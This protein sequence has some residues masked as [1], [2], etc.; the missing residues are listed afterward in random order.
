MPEQTMF[1]VKQELVNELL[2]IS[3]YGES[4]S[5]EQ[6]DLRT[7]KAIFLMEKINASDFLVIGA[8]LMASITYDQNGKR[9]EFREADHS[10]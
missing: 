8:R 9:L 6:L 3:K 1:E 7:S 4:W 10:L 5:P 2:A